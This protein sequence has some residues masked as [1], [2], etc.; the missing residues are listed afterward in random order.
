M[1]I[2]LDESRTIGPREKTPYWSTVYKLNTKY[3]FSI[4]SIAMVIVLYIKT[5]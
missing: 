1:L 3:F 5:N 2:L 4:V